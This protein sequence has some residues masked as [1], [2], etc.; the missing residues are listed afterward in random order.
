MKSRK[1]CVI[2]I[3][4]MKTTRANGGTE[5]KRAREE[6]RTAETRLMWMPGKRP[7]NVPARRP[8]RS[9]IIS[10]KNIMRLK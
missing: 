5:D 6:R 2:D 8:R 9:A 4:T 1:V 3:E 10:S 7:V